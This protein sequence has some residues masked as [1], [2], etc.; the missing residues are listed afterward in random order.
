MYSCAIRNQL[1]L[2]YARAYKLLYVLSIHTTVWP[3][4][5]FYHRWKTGIN[6]IF[7]KSNPKIIPIKDYA[8]HVYNRFLS[9]ER[10]FIYLILLRIVGF[11]FFYAVLAVITQHCYHDIIVIIIIRV[12]YIVQTYTYIIPTLERVSR[13]QETHWRCDRHARRTVSPLPRYPVP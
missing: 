5:S 4:T 3:C 12:T 2:D 8:T 1:I 10:F 7:L 6:N 11:F 13:A 9:H